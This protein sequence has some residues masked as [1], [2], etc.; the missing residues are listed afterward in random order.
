[1]DALNEI[2]FSHNSLPLVMY[3]YIDILYD[4]VELYMIYTYMASLYGRSMVEMH[5]DVCF[6][7]FCWVDLDVW[8]HP[9]AM[10]VHGLNSMSRLLP[11]VRFSHKM[12]F[13]GW[14]SKS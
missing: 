4:M 5:N 3:I 13:S 12:N 6:N 8:F 11:P 2:A 7:D 9:G 1:M 14:V 10:L